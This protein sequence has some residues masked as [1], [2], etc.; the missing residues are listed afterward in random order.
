MLRH[1]DRAPQVPVPAA[2]LGHRPLVHQQRRQRAADDGPVLFLGV[3]RREL[4]PEHG[5]VSSS[6]GT[7]CRCSTSASGAT[8]RKTDYKDLYYGRTDDKRQIY[9]LTIAYGDPGQVPHHRRS[10]TGARSEFNQAYRNTA[11]GASP[12]PGGTQT[13]TTF[14]WGTEQHPGQLAGRAAG[15]LGGD[16]QAALTASASWHEHR[17]RRRLLVGQ[18]RRAP[19]ATTAARWSTTSP[20]T[21]KTKRFLI[22]ADYRINKNWSGDRRLR[23]RELRLHRRPDAR[24]PGL[25]PVLPEHPWA[26]TTPAEQQ[27]VTGAFANPSYT[28]NIFC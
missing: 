23:V 8:W 17:R 10:A 20:T 27:L 16:R 22:K 6:T 5:Q 2:A 24:L 18:L 28:N 15:R 4:R 9:D 26:R 12:M 13:A 3:R 19:A 11:S 7:R 14:D 1:A 25:L 21:P